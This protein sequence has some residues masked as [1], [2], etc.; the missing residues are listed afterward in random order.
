VDSADD[1]EPPNV[2][3][4]CCLFGLS[5]LIRVLRLIYDCFHDC[6]TFMLQFWLFLFDSSFSD[7]ERLRE[8]KKQRKRKREKKK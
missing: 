3:R 5:E 8:R 2:K 7:S 1:P 6:E 4:K